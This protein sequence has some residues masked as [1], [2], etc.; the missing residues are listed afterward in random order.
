MDKT[1]YSS[2]RGQETY[3]HR[4]IFCSVACGPIKHSCHMGSIILAYLLE[5]VNSFKG[6]ARVMMMMVLVYE[7]KI[8]SHACPKP[9]ITFGS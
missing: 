8:W 7:S 6:K 3:Y 5:L 4:L 1:W 9:N 2:G